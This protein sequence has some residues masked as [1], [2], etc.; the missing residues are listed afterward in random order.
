MVPEGAYPS[1]KV[2]QMRDADELARR[3]AERAEA[4]KEIGEYVEA[5]WDRWA[6]LRA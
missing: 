6:H 2:V 4:L 5:E 3:D 1:A